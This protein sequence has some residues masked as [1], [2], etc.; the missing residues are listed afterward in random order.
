MLLSE[1]FF[2]VLITLKQGKEQI[3][4]LP[5][6]I[7]NTEISISMH[8]THDFPCVSISLGSNFSYQPLSA[9]ENFPHSALYLFE[10]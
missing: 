6:T 1:K 4:Y 7:L 8:C 5:K 9:L 3:Y 2:F 10:Y